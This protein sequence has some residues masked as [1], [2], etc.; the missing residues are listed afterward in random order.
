MNIR[1]EV[2][3]SFLFVLVGVVLVLIVARNVLKKPKPKPPGY[4]E[5]EH[6]EDGT[7]RDGF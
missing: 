1:W 2:L 5:E 3:P 4:I 7:P 6:N